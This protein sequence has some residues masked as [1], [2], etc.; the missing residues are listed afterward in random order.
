MQYASGTVV[1]EKNGHMRVVVKW[2]YPHALFSEGPQLWPVLSFSTWW[3]NIVVLEIYSV[4]PCLRATD[5]IHEFPPRDLISMTTLRRLHES[6]L[7]RLL[8]LSKH[9]K[10]D[11]VVICG[12]FN[13]TPDSALYHYM[14]EGELD[15]HGLNRYTC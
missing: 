2:H 14:V 3:L 8:R 13:M 5:D 4:I 6:L 12:D 11:G 7:E 10:A 15:V 1:E 9:S